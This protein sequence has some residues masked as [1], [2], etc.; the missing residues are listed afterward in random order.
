MLHV[1][2]LRLLLLL[3]VLSRRR[4]SHIHHLRL[5]LLRIA[6]LLRIPL[7]R[8]PALPLLLHIHHLL[9]NGLLGI[10]WLGL[11]VPAA[12]HGPTHALHASR[13]GCR[14]AALVADFLLMV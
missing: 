5:W 11:R 12:T 13:P 3:H 1:H 10:A 14:V 4:P 8:V 7:A 2:N 6:R 9:G